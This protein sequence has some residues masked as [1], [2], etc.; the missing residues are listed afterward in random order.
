MIIYS[1][2]LCTYFPNYSKEIEKIRSFK[3]EIAESYGFAHEV[4]V[5]IY[6]SENELKPISYAYQ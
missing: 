6:I 2:H 1:K 4:F 3:I 5:V